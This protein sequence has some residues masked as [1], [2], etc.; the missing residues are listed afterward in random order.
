MKAL[1][2]TADHLLQF[3]GFALNRMF[4]PSSL[5]KDS[6]MYW[7]ANILISILFTALI[8]G[9]F[10]MAAAILLELK[11]ELWTLALFD[12]IAYLVCICLIILRG[13]SYEI[14]A[15]VSLFMIYLMG[16][17]IIISVG[18]LSGGPVWLFTFAVLAGVLFGSKAAVAAVFLNGVTL[19][20]LGWFIGSG[21]FGETFPFFNTSQ[22]MV[23]AIVNFIV[24]NVLASASVSV[25]VRGLVSGHRKE[26]V[27]TKSLEREHRDLARIKKRLEVEI[28]ERK[29]AEKAVRESEQKYRLLADNVNDM[30]WMMDIQQQRLTYVSPSVKKIRGYSPEEVMGQSLE[31]IMTPE[32]YKRAIKFLSEELAADNERATD[33]S[34]TMEVEQYRKDGTTIWT[35]IM[36]SF[37]RDERKNPV[38]VLGVARDITER[39]EAE[40]ALRE[41]EEKLARSKKMESLGLMAGTIAHDLNN[42]LSGIVSYPELLL[43]DLPL[44]SPLR[45][46]VEIIKGSGQ[47]AAD[48]VADLL[49]VA[50]GVATG[51]EVVNLN[52]I[53]KEYM[54]SA[55]QKRIEAINQFV[56]FETDL[57]PELLNIKCSVSH[58]KKSLM[59]L[60]INASEAIEDRGTVA[61]STRNLYLDEPLKGY[62]DVRIGEYI[63]LTVSDNGIGISPK[64]IERIF[65]PFYTNKTMGR[66]GTG[67]GLT[68]VWNTVQDHDGYINVKAR[69]AGTA[70]EIYLPATREEADAGKGQ[71]LPANYQGHGERILVVDDEENQKIIAC[72]LLTKLGYSP[73]AVSSGE[74]AVEYLKKNPVD[75]VL[76]DMI[77]PKGINGLETYKRI[78]EIHPGQRAIIASGFAE[79]RD[80]KAAQELGAGKYM[81]KPYTLDK[82]GVVISQELER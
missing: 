19:T 75:L 49:T 71:D 12:V 20:A 66:N 24:L 44:D 34:V 73:E 3:Q 14:R 35:E 6:L 39:R 68:V 81:K 2:N 37:V 26:K 67:L 36:A 16:S 61:V 69:E 21:R 80:V 77:M 10:A 9:P 8:F 79:T 40:A 1:K 74:E 52:R 64:H 56:S 15:A 23:A 28:E 31:E 53:V 13:F 70:F 45:R 72:E 33:R 59:N 55:E 60:V 38:A 41:K 82:L 50:R 32:S 58:I 48:V 7:R 29:Q 42:I 22:A 4:Q 43:M 57:D 18:P 65:E 30:I 63:L 78:I 17:V 46:P 62:E 27:L 25:L 76:L 5:K 51:K 54:D 47:R 11:E